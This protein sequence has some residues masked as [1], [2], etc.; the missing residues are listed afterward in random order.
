MLMPEKFHVPIRFS[1]DGTFPALSIEICRTPSMVP[2]LLRKTLP[3]T[4]AEFMENDN[5]PL[6][7]VSFSSPPRSETKHL[8]SC[9]KSRL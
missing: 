3:V 7:Y 5:V 1:S 4:P 2:S 8:R 6:S 9:T